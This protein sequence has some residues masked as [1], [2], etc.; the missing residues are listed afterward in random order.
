MTTISTNRV[1]VSRLIEHLN[2]AGIAAVCEGA[3]DHEIIGMRSL[4]ELA[5]GYLGFYRGES[6]KALEALAIKGGVVLA[7]RGLR[8][9]MTDSDKLVCWVDNPDL[10]A[11]IAG[12][13]FLN[14]ASSGIHASAHIEPSAV[15]GERCS[16]GA[17]VVVGIDVVI[18]DGVVIQENSVVKHC[19][20][21]AGTRIM[22]GVTIG[23]EGLG[24]H[25]NK[26]GEWIHMPHFGRV[27]IG[28]NVLIQDNSCIAR[29]SLKNTVLKDGVA[30]GPLSA[31]AHNAVIGRN[32]F[33]GQCVTVAGSVKIGDGTK[34]WG[35]S[36]IRD[37]VTIGSRCTIGMGA[38][39][40]R[41]VTDGKTVVGNPAREI[42]PND[43][44]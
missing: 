20:I 15:I 30:I 33:I 28:S 21:G 12:T 23:S 10:A 14:Q 19:S 6:S 3:L 11:C 36:S 35:N 32:V 9:S 24:S 17:N 41:N 16:I 7:R 42:P 2:N 27:H 38:V 37:G 43:P 39:V 31:I 34:V 4:D 44:L 26:E 25:Q 18:E 1:T 8:H 22:P 29:G 13:L 5:S 40:V